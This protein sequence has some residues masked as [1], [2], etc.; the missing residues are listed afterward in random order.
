MTNGE[1]SRHWRFPVVTTV[2]FVVTALMNTLQFAVHGTLSNLERTPAGLHGEWWRT[3]TALFGQDGGVAGTVWNL[4]MFVMVG[5][6]AEQVISRPRWLIG[7]FGAGLAGEFAG[8]AWQPVGAGD[9]VAICGLAGAI[10]VTL[11]FGAGRFTGLAAMV[12]LFWCGGLAAALWAPLIA[13]GFALGALARIAGDRGVPVG[14]PAAV[15]GLAAGVALAA[16]HD[17]HG[18]AL[19]AGVVIAAV[20]AVRRRVAAA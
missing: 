15:L 1:P 2:V 6:V 16:N 19:L 3:V 4:V 7:Y 12:V 5:V 20:P 13:S 10:A 11:W 8:Y 14:R 9:S 17:I 18:A